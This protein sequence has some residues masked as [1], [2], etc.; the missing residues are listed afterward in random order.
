M[1]IFI[2]LLLLLNLVFTIDNSS[3]NQAQFYKNTYGLI[4]GVDNYPN[5]GFNMQLDYGVS[6]AKAIYKLI[7][8]NYTFSTCK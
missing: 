8:E 1:S 2:P 7:S 3:E 5:L 6:D 4:V